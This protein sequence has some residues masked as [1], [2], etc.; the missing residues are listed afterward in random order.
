MPFSHDRDGALRPG[1]PQRPPRVDDT[2]RL[3]FFRT[4]VSDV[5]SVNRHF[6]L[7]KAFWTTVKIWIHANTFFLH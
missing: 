1:L 7:Q 2:F 6:Y 3:T 5:S 4:H